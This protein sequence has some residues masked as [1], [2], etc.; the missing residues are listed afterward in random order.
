MLTAKLVT[1]SREIQQIAA[2]S[3]ANLSTNI[4]QVTK[5]KEGFVSWVYTPEILQTLHAIAPSV[6]VMDGDILAGYA[7]TLTPECLASYPPAIP[8]YEHASTLTHNGISLGS[9]RFY[10]MGQICVA[11]PYRGQG[12]V[13]TLYAGHKKFYSPQYDLLVTEIATTNPRS[14][15]AHQKVGFQV[16]DTH[17]DPQ[18]HWDVVAWDWTAPAR[19]SQ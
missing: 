1:T 11:L 15:K 13:D 3:N 9:Q 14:L 16:I 8:S 5:A 19:S 4:S 6:I 17:H 18:G 7:L 2:L 12:L 10:I